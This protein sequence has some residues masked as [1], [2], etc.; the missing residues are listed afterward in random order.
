[1]SPTVAVL[2]PRL[3]LPAVLIAAGCTSRGP[4]ATSDADPQSIV[5]S[6]LDAFDL[7][8]LTCAP[9]YADCGGSGTL[10]IFDFLCFQNA[11]VGGCP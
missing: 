1:M 7:S 8:V 10:D 11:F 5:E 9:C 3:A 4:L 6:G 2:M